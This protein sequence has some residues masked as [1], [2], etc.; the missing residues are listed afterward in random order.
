M[1]IVK[2]ILKVG[3]KTSAVLTGDV[4]KSKTAVF[5]QTKMEMNLLLKV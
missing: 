3:N 2:D 1:I 5:F 4:K